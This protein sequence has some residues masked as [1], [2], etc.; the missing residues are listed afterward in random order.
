MFAYNSKLKSP[1][2]RLFCKLACLSLAFAMTPNAVL[3][4]EDAYDL[5]LIG[6]GLKICSEWDIRHCTKDTQFDGTPAAKVYRLN[7]ENLQK[8]TKARAF[9][10]LNQ[11]TQSHLNAA[12][13]YFYANEKQLSSPAQIK[14]AF[15]QALP[16]IDGAALFTNLPDAIYYALLDFTEQAP[17]QQERI[18][19]AASQSQASKSIFRQFVIQSA[20]KNTT[21]GPVNL[22]FL[23][24]SA[25]D[26]YAAVHW[27]QQVLEQAAKQVLPGKQVNINW[28]AL[29]KSLTQ[30]LDGMANGTAS[31]PD[32]TK[33]QT[34]NQL[35]GRDTVYPAHYQQQ[36]QLCKNPE[37]V[38]EMLANAH[39]LFI[40]G[41][42]Q[43]RTLALFRTQQGT[44][45]QWHQQ[46]MKKIASNR[47]LL[48]GTSA[49]TAVQGGGIFRNRP[50]P[51]ITG[52]VS[53]VALI[54]GAFALPP[55]PFGCEKDG[56]CPHSL[57]EDDLTYD[58][59]GGLGSFNLGIVDTHFSARDRQARLAVLAAATQTRFGFG[60][61]ENT[62]LLVNRE[63]NGD[64]KLKVLGERGVFVVDL[65]NAIVKKQAGKH[66]I[67]GLSH[68]LHHGDT[69]HYQAV[70]DNLSLSFSDS[71]EII[72]EKTMVVATERGEFRRQ[73]SLHCGTQTFHRWADKG[74]AWLVNASEETVFALNH[75]NTVPQCSYKDLLFGIEN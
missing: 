39:G 5:L 6:G 15:A 60:V 61:D 70:K 30:T 42:D 8:V 33:Y 18:H 43:M 24:A 58:S 47:I 17:L 12:F 2:Y 72:K 38:T 35:Y 36:L 28:L 9:A 52:G 56:N 10:N 25:R 7:R 68:Y 49:G 74:I 57:L 27:Y 23:T 55:A 63:A 13:D 14:A 48:A 75:S 45:R 64:R 54:R 21:D 62:A 69:G 3:A 19:F 26:P 59:A 29:D 44:S 66:Q 11:E 1:I 51:M 34:A 53:E 67:I 37:T 65:V 71:S 4:K 20:L 73:V 16:D 31:C 22:L 40:N 50:V 32:L 46:L 41:G